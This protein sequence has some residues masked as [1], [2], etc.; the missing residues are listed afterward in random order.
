MGCALKLV[1]VELE[2]SSIEWF[3]DD[4][5]LTTR[6]SNC[7]NNECFAGNLSQNV[8]IDENI[9]ANSSTK[10]CYFFF[11]TIITILWTIITIL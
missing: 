8:I 3:H 7:L 5:K 2:P 11:L 6:F 9:A 4:V 10:V 1:D